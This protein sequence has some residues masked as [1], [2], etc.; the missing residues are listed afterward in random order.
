MTDNNQS[1]PPSGNPDESAAANQQW[2]RV[3]GRLRAEFGNAAYK[4]W[5]QPISLTKI[6][7]GRVTMQVPTPFMR[8][9]VMSRYAD[10]IRA[11]WRGE[12]SSISSIHIAVSNDGRPAKQ[13]APLSAPVSAPLSAPMNDS[14]GGQTIVASPSIDTQDLPDPAQG[15]DPSFVSTLN[16]RFSFDNFVVGKSN[17]FAH[18]A[19][20]RV[21]EASKLPFNPLFIYGGVGLGK[22][23]LMHAIAWQIRQEDP[24]PA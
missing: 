8:E 14:V 9:W 15:A 3:R 5:L 17:E 22:T 1:T 7:S 6:S 20:R 2:D 18:A 4:S 12:D 13:P 21:V 16:P 10:R 24:S 19:A 11:L 23:H